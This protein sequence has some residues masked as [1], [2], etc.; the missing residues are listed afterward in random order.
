[1]QE[2]IF[3]LN[4]ET[5]KIDK[6]SAEDFDEKLDSLRK[7]LEKCLQKITRLGNCSLENFEISLSL[8]A[9]IF[10]LTTEGSIKLAYKR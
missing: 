2:E 8:K 3:Y 6:I 9:G 7:M 5:G 10:F 1:M 4:E